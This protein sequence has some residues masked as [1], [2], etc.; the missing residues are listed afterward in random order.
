M[1]LRPNIYIPVF[2]RISG[3]KK[4]FQLARF[5]S[6]TICASVGLPSTQRINIFVT[7]YETWPVFSPQGQTKATSIGHRAVGYII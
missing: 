1:A 5:Q 6:I 4:L 7:D 3:V 2:K